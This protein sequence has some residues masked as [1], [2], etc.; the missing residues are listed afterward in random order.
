MMKKKSNR[1]SKSLFRQQEVFSIRKLSLGVASVLLGSF[2]VGGSVV[3]AEEISGGAESS[4]VVGAEEKPPV[5]ST[6][7]VPVSEGD[8]VVA[9]D[10]HQ[11]ENSVAP[12]AVPASATVTPQDRPAEEVE[13]GPENVASVPTE[14]APSTSS[15]SLAPE[16]DSQPRSLEKDGDA[17]ALSSAVPAATSSSEIVQPVVEGGQVLPRSASEVSGDELVGGEFKDEESLVAVEDSNR[18]PKLDSLDLNDEHGYEDRSASEEAPKVEEENRNKRLEYFAELNRSGFSRIEIPE[19]MTMIDHEAFR[20]NKT[21]KEIVLPTTLT[22]IEYGAF[23]N[24]GLEK[25]VLPASLTSIGNRAF[26]GISTLKE[27]VIP[28]NVTYAPN[29][30][31]GSENLKK[32]TFEDGITVIP[33]SILAGTS[34]EEIHLPSSVE[35]IDSYAFSE[36]KYLKKINLKDGVKAIYSGAFSG[37]GS[38][39]Q[40]DLP[41]TLE[42]IADYAFSGT[43]SLASIDLPASV[44]QIGYSAFYDSGLT[45]IN[46]PANLESIGNSAFYSTRLSEVKLPASLKNLGW[47]AFSNIDSLKKVEVNS[48]IATSHYSNSWF[49]PFASSPLTDVTIKDGVTVVADRMF[50]GQS[51]VTSLTLPSSLLEVRPYAFTGIGIESL[52][53]PAGLQKL[54]THSFARSSN[55]KSVTIPSSLVEGDG[56][57]IDSKNLVNISLAPGTTKIIDGLFRGTGFTEFTIPEGI[58]EIG[59]NAFS[60]NE[61]LTTITLPSTLRTIG[62]NAFSNTSLKR[63]VLPPGMKK[64]PDGLLQGTKVEEFV[65]P[66]GVEEI[67]VQAFAYNPFLKSVVLPSSLKKIGYGAFQNTGIESITFKDG[68]VEIDDYAFSNTNLKSVLLPNSVTRLGGSA[69]SG[70]STLTS[71]T[72]SEGLTEINVGTFSGTSLERVILPSAVTIIHGSAFSGISTLKDITFS[73]GLKR[74]DGYAFAGTGLTD[75]TLPN[76]LEYLGSQAFATESLRSIHI[77]K[78]LKEVRVYYVTDGPFTGA[79]NLQ[80]VTFE[81]GIRQIVANLFRGSHI[82]S[83]DLPA[84]VEEIGSSAFAYSALKE[85]G[86][87]NGLKHIGASAFSE[88]PLERITLPD[89]VTEIG[90][91]AFYRTNLESIH[92]PDSVTAIGYSAFENSYKLKQATLSASMTYV[93]ASMFSGT[94][95]SS[96]VIPASVERIDGAA[97]LNT[98]LSQ[99]SLPEKLK[100]IGGAAFSGTPLTSTSFPA[101]LEKIGDGAFWQTSLKEVTIP[102][103]I[104][105]LGSGVFGEIDTLKEAHV[106]RDFVGGYA[107]FSG[108]SILEKVTFEEGRT[109]IPSEFFAN[110]GVKEVILPKELKVIGSGA[111]RSTHNLKE[112][113]LGE[114]LEELGSEA[115]QN[116]GLTQVNLPNSLPYLSYRVFADSTSLQSVRLPDTLTTIPE[117]AFKNTGLHSLNLPSSVT[118][119]ERAAFANAKIS[120]IDFSTGLETIGDGAFS[121]NQFEKLELPKSLKELGYFAFSDNKN[122]TFL[123]IN[124]DLE[125]ARYDY[126]SGATPF[127]HS[128]Y[129]SDTKSLY[130]EFK[131]GVTKIPARLFAGAKQVIRVDLPEGLK[132][133]GE[134]AFYG[135]SI[136]KDESKESAPKPPANENS[137]AEKEQQNAP[138]DAVSMTRLELPDSLE[139]IGNHAFGGIDTLTSVNIPKNLVVADQAF[140]G[141]RNLTHLR[142]NVEGVRIPDGMLESTGIATFIVP[143]GITEIGK[144]ALRDNKQFDIGADPFGVSLVDRIKRPGLTNVILPSTLTKIDSR[145]FESTSIKFI[146]IPNGVSE[147]GEGAFRF[148]PELETVKLPKE[149]KKLG[150]Y[151]FEGNEKMTL[152]VL[153]DKVES[154]D[155]NAFVNMPNL[156]KVYIPASVNSIGENLIFNPN[157]TFYVAAGSYAEKYMKERNIPYEISGDDYKHYNDGIVKSSRFSVASQTLKQSGKLALDLNYS[158][159]TAGRTIADKEI[160]ITLP[161]GAVAFEKKI[162]IDGKEQ[163]AIIENDVLR[164][165]NSADSSRIQFVVTTKANELT[166]L[167]LAAQVLY[168][169]YGIQKSEV[170]GHLKEEMPFLMIKTDTVIP[171][172]TLRITGRTKPNTEVRFEVIDMMVGEQK[173]DKFEGKVW[174]FENLSSKPVISDS[175]GQFQTVLAFD[176]DYLK[177]RFGDGLKSFKVRAIAEVEGVEI[178]T[179]SEKIVVSNDAP[180]LIQ[181]L[182]KHNGQE[183]DLLDNKVNENVIFR[184]NSKFEFQVKFYNSEDISGVWVNTVRNGVKKRIQ[185][186]QKDDVY[187][188]SA[189]FDDSNHDFIPSGFAVE[190]EKYNKDKD[191]DGLLTETVMTADDMEKNRWLKKNGYPDLIDLNPDSWDVS[192][193]DLLIFAGVTYFDEGRLKQFFS[194]SPSNHIEPK[195]IAYNEKG[196]KSQFYDLEISISDN[197]LFKK[198]KFVKQLRNKYSEV[199]DATEYHDIMKNLES[200][201]SYFIDEKGESVIISY[202]GTD[203]GG[204]ELVHDTLIIKGQNTIERTARKQLKAILSDINDNH[205]NIKNIYIVGHSL[206]GY[207]AYQASDEILIGGNERD[208]SRLKKVINFNGPGFNNQDAE[209]KRAQKVNQEGKTRI[210]FYVLDDYDFGN[211]LATL[212]QFPED[213]I[214]DDNRLKIKYTNNAEAGFLSHYAHNLYTFF[215]YLD[216]GYRSSKNRF[217]DAEPYI[218]RPIFPEV[219]NFVLTLPETPNYVIDPS[220]RVLNSVT[221]KPVVNATAKVYYKDKDGKEVLWN[222]GDYSQLNPVLTTIHGEYAWDVPEGLWKVKIEKDGYEVAES[223]WLPVPPPQTEVNFNLQPKTYSLEF[224]LDGGK[225]ISILP[226]SY[227]TEVELVLPSAEK[228]G[229]DFLGWFDNETRTGLP[230]TTTLFSTVGNKKLWAAWAK[231]L[232]KELP[233]VAPTAVALPT[234]Q[235]TRVERPI[236]SVEVIYLEDAN[237]LVGESREEIGQDGVLVVEVAE[238]ILDGQVTETQE[239]EVSRTEATP[240]KVYRGTK[241]VSVTPV[242]TTRTR[243]EVRVLTT[244]QILELED[245]ELVQGQTREEASINGQVLVEIIE[246]LTDGQVTASS[247]R[248]ISR[249]EAVPRKVYRGTKII[250]T[251]LVTQLP[252]VAPTA[253]TLPT[254]KLTRVERPIKSETVIYLEDPTLP[255]GEIRVEEGLAGLLVVDLAEY[256]L[257]GQIVKIEEFILSHQEATPRKIYR[258]RKQERRAVA[259]EQTQAVHLP[260]AEEGAVNSQSLPNTGQTDS[261]Y[262]AILGLSLFLAGTALIKSKKDETV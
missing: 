176:M 93:P 235:L 72:L 13:A 90:D 97:F 6:E 178:K 15:S 51:G 66:E 244:D 257:D 10:D 68:L 189:Y 142:N 218:D 240:R 198:W 184:P 203:E 129:S 158:L 52:T 31:A 231:P 58:T 36:N 177:N 215:Y 64:I 38:L 63:I 117:E 254:V 134:S 132:E 86:L 24:S 9:P 154:I 82:E 157:T 252:T 55:L 222:A 165:K 151:L 230:V 101:S 14:T 242:I 35:T 241:V 45:S 200:I 216:H 173:I 34:V 110:T 249:T 125:H 26:A 87:Q 27:V 130:V 105:E 247:E 147:I 103:T 30:F 248:E 238:F 124:S 71:V 78:S 253:V 206:G 202:R 213:L 139:T 44:K 141:S 226:T 95:L 156:E 233:T 136:M 229:H 40:V 94:S 79:T 119:I 224:I 140:A 166:Q 186:S 250:E 199:A 62:A 104:K 92:I 85:I 48:N 191:G 19:G 183:L 251:P 196:E 214:L 49:S 28:K 260:S 185:L 153:P 123:Y 7:I 234:V 100:E 54:G 21:L 3:Q 170:L 163:E 159:D 188:A 172:N 182:M 32:V 20:G 227:M 33:A 146:D 246:T 67:G 135:T 106:A 25:L 112:I 261:V 181:F 109:E 179:D 219:K 169:E 174:L 259:T 162:K 221:G 204:L 195:D 148:S 114:K 18:E 59:A 121:G 42:Y 237:L 256:I 41:D 16:S 120:K 53:L 126:Y 46:L 194:G 70:I 155:V 81:T 137:N 164:I 118:R 22:T 116:S 150:G 239:F 197:R 2:F 89:S 56:A 122:L 160:R 43:G 228:E 223:D 220:G 83:I 243:Q 190:V 88:S 168:K 11:V 65:I 232:V 47:G 17:S 74:I 5:A 255:V 187:T 77:P 39:A 131:D 73:D 69:F 211:G 161:K 4:L 91:S 115:F 225:A 192:D 12:Q 245:S 99:V 144:Y 102:K 209:W 29:I 37:N 84:T 76:Q 113:D 1:Y 127:E 60:D 75:V 236:K 180:V 152:L 171:S 193:R 201:V 212:G 205:K 138:F 23:E 145:T 167:Q 143:E 61:N 107:T 207:E 98:K 208:L 80:T 258:G 210:R 8:S 111:F 262:P 57:F 149:L 50:E 108:S 133:I 96:I 217:K 128:N 175:T